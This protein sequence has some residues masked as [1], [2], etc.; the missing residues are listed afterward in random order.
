MVNGFLL[1]DPSDVESFTIGDNRTYMSGRLTTSLMRQD[2]SGDED[3]NSQ[4]LRPHTGLNDLPNP[5]K[6]F[7]SGR[8]QKLHVLFATSSDADPS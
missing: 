7:Q 3:T 6:I 2:A 4:P 8:V 1:N 5:I